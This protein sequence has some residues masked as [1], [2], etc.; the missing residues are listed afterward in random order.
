[1]MA[2]NALPCPF[3]NSN[4]VVQVE[5]FTGNYRYG[6][7]V[8][9][10]FDQCSLCEA[11]TRSFSYI[12]D[13]LVEKKNAENSAL[14]AW[15]KRGNNL[16]SECEAYWYLEPYGR[17]GYYAYC[18]RCHHEYEYDGNPLPVCPHCKSR[19]NLEPIYVKEIEP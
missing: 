2:N 16:L 1:M 11:S 3:C 13:N 9:I 8:Y 6:K 19:M 5:K 17:Y 15:N 14:S 10:V 18:S 4:D 7:P 12:I